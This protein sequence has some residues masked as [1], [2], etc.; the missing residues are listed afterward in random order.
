MTKH[1]IAHTDKQRCRNPLTACAFICGLAVFAIVST[2]R[3]NPLAADWQRFNAAAGRF[4]IEM[5]GTPKASETHTESFIGSITNHI[6]VVWN[7]E[8]NFTVD[9]SD[10]PSIAVDFA[11]RDTIYGHTKGS[12]LKKTLS[13]ETS[14]EDITVQGIAGKRLVYDMPPMRGRPTM[15]GHA[16]LLLDDARLYVFDVEHPIGDSEG[17]AERFL[18]S[19]R[20]E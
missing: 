12:L 18:S 6:F 16:Y 1:S 14:Y 15:Q 3:N 2:P 13:K 5:P 8:Q 19:I 17:A 11:G 10:L 7:D 9:Y 20:I 4:S